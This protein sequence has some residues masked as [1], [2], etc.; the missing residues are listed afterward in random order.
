MPGLREVSSGDA[1][2]EWR[3]V[4][5][6]VMTGDSDVAILRHG[7]EIAVLIPADDYHAIA[8]ELEEVRLSRLAESIY[9]EYLTDIE[10]ARSYDEVQAELLG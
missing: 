2:K 3:S 4:L 9:E 1:R 6:A 10:S 5:D 7:Q 8:E